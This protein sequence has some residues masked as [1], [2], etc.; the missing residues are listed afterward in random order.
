M[1]VGIIGLG[2][3]GIGMG[4]R[5][6][7]RNHTVRAYDVSPGKKDAAAK[8]G[9]VWMPSPLDVVNA[10]APPRVVIVMV[11]A[12][13][14]TE[15]AIQSV[16]PALEAADVLIDGGNSY[17]KD[18]MDRAERLKKRGIRFLDAG[19]SGGVWGFKKGF[20][21]MVGGDSEA[22][23]VAEPL[24]RDLAPENGYA[25]V[26]ESGAGHYA[27]MIHNGIEYGM[28]QVYGEGFELLE[29]SDFDFDLAGLAHLWNHG[30][31]I[32]SWLLELAGLAFEESPDL[33]DI[34]GYVEDS[35]EG[36]W[37]V[38]EAI[39]LDV[40]A[41]V[42]TLSLMSRFRSRQED[43]FSAKVIA[44]LRQQFGGHSVK[45]K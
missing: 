28:L 3:M 42:I 26:G 6:A 13:T 5:L 29:K 41:P 10:L 23:G 35:G 24:I 36:R 45:A 39:D 14:P 19:I 4:G 20:C 7:L 18:S 22:F 15:E 9:I 43:S 8:A 21:I 12:G 40:P 38:R 30:S 27:K 32:R 1:D 11:P 16:E 33:A 31:V 2:R 34:R 44:A 17:Y 37:T 25:H